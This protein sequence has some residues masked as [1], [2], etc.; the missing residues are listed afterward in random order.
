MAAKR[1]FRDIHKWGSI[2]IA[3]PLGLM[4]GAGILLMLKKDID[5]IQPPTERG[6][7]T[8]LP[9]VDL[10][11]MLKSA[12]TVSEAGISSWQDLSR[13]DVKPD[14]GIVK[15]ITNHDYEVQIDGQTGKVLSHAPRRSDFI[16]TLHDG[17]FFGDGVKKFVFLPVGIILAIL[18]MT[19]IY[20]FILPY[21]KRAKRRKDKAN[22][23]LLMANK[24]KKL[25]IKPV[26]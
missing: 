13:V 17:S 15:F 9:A 3:I 24:D 25:S 1:L 2:I 10:A 6:V 14:K 8:E 19:G 18:W 20:L 4:I 26:E 22:R 11:T 23:M 5:W 12:S 21:V 16:E 7:S